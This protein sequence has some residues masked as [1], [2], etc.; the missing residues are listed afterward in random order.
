VAVQGHTLIPGETDEWEGFT[1]VQPEGLDLPCQ[2][3]QPQKAAPQNPWLWCASSPEMNLPLVRDL[4]KKGFHIVYLSSEASASFSESMNHWDQVYGWL[5]DNTSLSEKALVEAS[6]RGA[7]T[8][9]AWLAKNP[10][11]AAGI[12]SIRPWLNLREA[13][14]A[15]LEDHDRAALGQWLAVKDPADF[16]ETPLA[17][18]T[19]LG[20]AIVPMMLIQEFPLDAWD[21]EQ[22]NKF[23]FDYRTAGKGEYDV[24]SCSEGAPQNNE[25]LLFHQCYFVMKH[26][27][28]LATT[29]IDEPVSKDSPW[30]VAD[31]SALPGVYELDDTLILE[32]GGDM[33]GIRWHGEAPSEP[34]EI[35]L[36]AMRIAGSD[37]FCGLT[38]PYGDS[39]FSLIIG[40]WGGTCVGIS[41]LNWLDAYN[42]ET[43]CFRNFNDHEWYTIRLRVVG[44]Q[45]EAWIDG[46]KLVDVA[47]DGR[48]VDVRWEMMA[49]TPL[50]IATWRTTGV[51]R[52]FQV[53]AL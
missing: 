27:G 4:L 31:L 38:V 13:E 29:K 42:N 36:E 18:A 7:L 22:Y 19:A 16:E 53:K 15:T 40:G 2:I 20:K 50:G 39:A 51:I 14:D 11:A 44:E 23:Y 9:F 6:G 24:I 1:R 35:S 41:N 10:E 49:V 8:A 37:F 52:N 30:T 28:Q 43:A 25:S 17:C 34:Y 33:T 5:K 48:D 3:I 12:L 26:S 21:M 47:V 45:I 32:K 46:E